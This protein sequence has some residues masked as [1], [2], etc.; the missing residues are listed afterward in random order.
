MAQ[1]WLEQKQR[2]EIKAG[3]RGREPRDSKGP[4][5]GP[6]AGA[7]CGQAAQRTAAKPHFFQFPSRTNAVNR[8]SSS[9]QPA[10][11]KTRALRIVRTL[12]KKTR[13]L[14]IVRNQNR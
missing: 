8:T 3:P 5:P 11:K 9:E 2:T 14:R 12:R 6:G 4:G 13:A 1:K 7:D 10:G